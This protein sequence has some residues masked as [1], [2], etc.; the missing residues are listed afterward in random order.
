MILQCLHEAFRGYMKDNWFL[1]EGIHGEIEDF[2]VNSK[3]K[4]GDL[5]AILFTSDLHL[6]HKNIISTCGR[7]AENCGQNFDT[8]EQM[9]VFLINKWNQKVKDN[10]EVY[11]LGDLTFRSGVSVKTYL[12]QLKGRKHLII[13]NHDFQWQKNITNMKDYFESVSNMEVIRLDGKIITLCHYPLLEW[14]GSR[15]AKNQRTSISWLIH[16]HIHNTR[17]NV[18]EY[19]RDNLPCAL[20]CGV[21]INGFEPVTFEELLINN[22]KWYGRNKV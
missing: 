4:E 8:V 2:W 22:N 9:N 1:L 21:D 16:G 3:I 15:R 17:D 11:I 6:G 20:N 5:M 18:F 14:N 12:M 13:G 10:D 7:N 19:I